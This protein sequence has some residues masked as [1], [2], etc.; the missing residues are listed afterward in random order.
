MNSVDLQKHYAR[1]LEL[2]EQGKFD[3]AVALYRSLLK[4]IPDADLVQYNLGL[5]LYEQKH[6]VE[7]AAAFS[8]AAEKNPDDQDYWFN[9]ALA[10]KQAGLFSEAQSAY[11]RAHCLQP[12]DPDILYNIGCCYQAAGDRQQAMESYERALAYSRE[13]S[14]A[15]SNLAYCTHLQGDYDR[16]AVLYNR[17]LVLRPDHHAAR[18]MVEALEGK[19]IAA[20]P[21]EYVQQLFDGYSENFDQDLVNNLSYRVPELLQHLL[22]DAIGQGRRDK[23]VVDLGCG[24]GLS[25]QVVRE[26]ASHLTGVDL[27][28]GMVKEAEKKE[29]Y[30]RLAVGDVV[31]F[32]KTIPEPVDLLIAADVLTYLGDLEPLFQAAVDNAEA[33]G[34]FCFSTEQGKEAGWKLRVSGRYGHHRQYIQELA[35]STGWQVLRCDGADIRKERGLWIAGDLYLLEKV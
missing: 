17:L 5:A 24:T 23:K 33:G 21:P 14:S 19:N 11:E 10:F 16:A 25:G 8:S 4:D 15:L 27:S 35:D 34:L 1:A 2:H 3:E 20:P 28:A 31:D 9:A 30:D 22:E 12:E 6:Y 18:Y 7:A 13:H 32:L 29:C 26:Y